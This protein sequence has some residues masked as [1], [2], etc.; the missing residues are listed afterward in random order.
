MSSL[1]IRPPAVAGLFY[2]GHPDELLGSID[3]LL[4]AHAPRGDSVR[5]RP[6]AL[7]VPHAG[8]R[9]SGAV[10]ARAYALLAPHAAAI[11][12]VALFGPA[13]RVALRGLAIPGVE[14]MATPLGVVPL[15]WEALRNVL[16][17]PQVIVDDAVHAL[18]HSL[19]V[20]LPFLQRVLEDFRI[21][22]F[23]VGAAT[24]HEVAEVM[25]R[26][27]DGEQTLIVVSSD[28]S[29]YHPYAEA[30]RL[31]AATVQRMLRLQSLTDTGQACGA[32]PVNGLLLAARRHRLRPRLLAQCNSGDSAGDRSR[33]VG[34]AS[35]AFS[36]EETADV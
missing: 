7:I 5:E 1:P 29:H 21:L 24:P 6:K 36:A 2:P 4:G 12:R 17:L 32:I 14:G 25:E 3:D 28:L 31:D 34:Y 30:Q 10:A 13:H 20:H 35:L 33:V 26:L 22:P 11:R 23:A 18:E 9:Y 27:W 8:Y 15:D 19:E 16:S